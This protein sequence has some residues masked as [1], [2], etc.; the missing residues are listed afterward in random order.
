MKKRRSSVAPITIKK[1]EEWKNEYAT[2]HGLVFGFGEG[3]DA[4]GEQRVE[5]LFCVRAV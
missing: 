4:A 2:R 5:P 3:N 1:L